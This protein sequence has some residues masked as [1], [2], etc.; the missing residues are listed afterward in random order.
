MGIARRFSRIYDLKDRRG[1]PRWI[2]GGASPPATGRGGA[3]AA[4]SPTRSLLSLR[5]GFRKAPPARR[6]DERSPVR[7]P[8]GRQRTLPAR[9]VAGSDP[10]Y[11]RCSP[12]SSATRRPERKQPGTVGASRIRDDLNWTSARHRIRHGRRHT[13]AGA[14]RRSCRCIANGRLRHMLIGNGRLRHMLIGYAR[15]S[16]ADGSQSLDRLSPVALLRCR[17]RS[18][19]CA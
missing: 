9:S 16:K 4:A 3:G 19:S 5:T 12:R 7:R 13:A 6:T 18:V 14:G 11:S 2:H 17:A 8:P 15:V 1:K 10:R